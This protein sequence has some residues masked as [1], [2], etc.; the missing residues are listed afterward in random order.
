MASNGTVKCP[1]PMKAASNGVF[2]GDDPLD[3]AL[4]LLII[5]I[6]LVIVLTRLLAYLLR[7]LRQPRVVAE[8]I[9]S[10]LADYMFFF[11]SLVNCQFFFFPFYVL[12]FICLR[13]AREYFLPNE[14]SP[15]LPFK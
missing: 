8:I 12:F 5:Q 9:V 11:I 6:C 4:P 10:V 13:C 3:F 1:A 15:R 2:Q 7:P 14:L